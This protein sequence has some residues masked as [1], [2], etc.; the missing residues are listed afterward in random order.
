MRVTGECTHGDEE[1]IV[2]VNIEARA[3][4]SVTGS[5]AF[6]VVP[7]QHLSSV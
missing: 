5:V 2:A 3:P 6:T 1:R 7:S 4:T